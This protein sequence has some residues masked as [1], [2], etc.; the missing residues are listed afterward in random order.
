MIDQV[1]A[2]LK[3]HISDSA[4]M[5]TILSVLVIIGTLRGRDVLAGVAQEEVKPLREDVA[6]MSHKQDRYEE[7]VHEF[8]KDVRELYRVT[9]VLRSSP[10]LEAPFPEHHDDGGEP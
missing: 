10:R 2:Y 9:P 7:D 6:K 1:I 8:A 4:L 3:K 5:L